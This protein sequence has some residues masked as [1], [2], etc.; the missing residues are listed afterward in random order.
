MCRKSGVRIIDK[1]M[2]N[3]PNVESKTIK[4]HPI[5][6]DEILMQKSE[7]LGCLSRGRPGMDGEI[8][9]GPFY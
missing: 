3:Q 6:D 1:S 4:K 7:F 9:G 8:G 5:I 2:K